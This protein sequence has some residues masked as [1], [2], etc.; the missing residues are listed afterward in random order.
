MTLMFSHV[1][2]DCVACVCVCVNVKHEILNLTLCVV[3][4]LGRWLTVLSCIQYIVVHLMQN[5]SIPILMKK[6]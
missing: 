2:G 1:S 6:I 3:W 4:R 5:E